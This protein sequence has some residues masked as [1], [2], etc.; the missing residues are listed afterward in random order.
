VASLSLPM[1]LDGRV[2]PHPFLAGLDPREPEAGPDTLA[3]ALGRLAA[4]GPRTE[5]LA[6][7]LS[8]GAHRRRSVRLRAHR[9][10][11]AVFAVVAGWVVL[12]LLTLVGW[13]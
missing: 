10:E 4:S 13:V 11:G 12:G 9:L 3:G 1:P 2:E 7:V 5:A 8:P 6:G